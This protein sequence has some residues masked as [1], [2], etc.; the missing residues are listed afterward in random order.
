MAA[1]IVSQELDPSVLEGLRLLH[2]KDPDSTEQ[3]RQLWKQSVRERY[4]SE[5]EPVSVLNKIN[6]PSGLKREA[7]HESSD[8]FQLETKKS[9]LEAPSIF[10][11][12][13]PASPQGGSSN[14]FSYNITDDIEVHGSSSEEDSDDE[15]PLEILNADGICMKCKGSS[16]SQNNKL[17]E[18]VDCHKH[19]H[20]QCHFPPITD[21]DLSDPRFVWYCSSCEEN[22]STTTSSDKNKSSSSSLGI[23]KAS[24]ASSKSLSSSSVNKSSR[25]YGNS[26]HSSRSGISSS[27]NGSSSSSKLSTNSSPKHSSSSSHLMKRRTLKKHDKRKSSK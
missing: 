26:S 1:S 3:L 2:S 19:Y 20:Q 24:A 7:G 16:S 23:T 5:R 12:S 18:C 8:D 6:I 22:I 10:H 11:K 15:S 14:V 27:S 17:V 4:G 25:S 9:K 21:M 13:A